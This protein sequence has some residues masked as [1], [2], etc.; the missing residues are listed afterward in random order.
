MKTF[1][2]LLLLLVVAMTGGCATTTTT[3]NQD[4][5]GEYSHSRAY[6]QAVNREAQRHMMRVY[7]INF[8]SEEALRLQR[9]DAGGG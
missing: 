8:P 2:L 5:L 7:W 4:A 3:P 6:V 1:H 9:E